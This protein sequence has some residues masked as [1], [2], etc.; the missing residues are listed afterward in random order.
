MNDRQVLPGY[1]AVWLVVAAVFFSEVP[2]LQQTAVGDKCSHFI[3]TGR[4]IDGMR[5]YNAVGD[6]TNWYKIV[7]DSIC[8]MTCIA[9]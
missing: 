7:A 4:I 3:L 1:R 2:K 5:V 6:A 9:G 8:Q